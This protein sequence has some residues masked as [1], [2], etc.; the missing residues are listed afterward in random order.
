MPKMVNDFVAHSVEAYFALHGA[1]PEAVREQPALLTTALSLAELDARLAMLVLRGD[2]PFAEHRFAMR[3]S[4]TSCDEGA[5][6]MQHNF[7]ADFVF[8]EM[9]YIVLPDVD[10]LHDPYLDIVLTLAGGLTLPSGP[11]P[12]ATP[13]NEVARDGRAPAS[14]KAPQM[15]PFVGLFPQSL[16]AT[17]RPTKTRASGVEIA[18]AI[19]GVTTGLDRYPMRRDEAEEWLATHHGIRVEYALRERAAS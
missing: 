15:P 4:F 13:L 18:L 9:A 2:T 12:Y 17:L 8:C 19:R 7:A 10:A 5:L 6:Y 3:G 16:R 14:R 1:S 11:V